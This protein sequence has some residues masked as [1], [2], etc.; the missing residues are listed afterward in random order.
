MLRYSRFGIRQSRR[1]FSIVELLV[2]MTL[3]A[4]GLLS[5]V[6]ANTL[7]VRRRTEAR[8]RLA[9]VTAAANRI[10]ELSSGP[11]R[12]SAGAFNSPAG[13]AE[14][15]WAAPRGNASREIVDS[16]QFGVRPARLLVVRTQVPC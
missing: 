8:Q 2:A 7:F 11:C 4:V 6:G 9:A 10:A 5:L 16:V 12:S 13:I 15:W 14:Q 1:G 3:F